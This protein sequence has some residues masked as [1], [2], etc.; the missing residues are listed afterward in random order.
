MKLLEQSEVHLKKSF[1]HKA[2]DTLDHVLV[3]LGGMDVDSMILRSMILLKLCRAK[4]AMKQHEEALDYC[5]QAYT[6]LENPLPGM[7]AGNAR[8][9][10]V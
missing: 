1:N 3:A 4:A 6:A 10:A 8:I 7:P 9:E 5:E 2:V